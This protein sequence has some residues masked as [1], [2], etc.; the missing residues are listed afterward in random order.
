MSLYADAYN[1]PG[2][3]TR[4]KDATDKF[5]EQACQLASRTRLIRKYGLFSAIRLVPSS[6]NVERAGANLI[7][8]SN[9]VCHPGTGIKNEQMAK[10]IR[11][12]LRI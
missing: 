12:S 4:H 9:Q 7:G 8:L 1:N 3:T 10:K 2:N 6:Q 11:E 5:R